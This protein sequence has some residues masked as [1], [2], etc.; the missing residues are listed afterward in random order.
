MFLHSTCAV[1]SQRFPMESPS[2]RGLRKAGSGGSAD[3]LKFGAEVRNCIWHLCRTGVKVMAMTTCLTARVLS[4]PHYNAL[5]ISKISRGG[6]KINVS[7][8]TIKISFWCWP[9]AENW[10]PHVCEP[11]QFQSTLCIFPY[12]L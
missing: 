6:V 9:P 1:L 8:N 11:S 7:R 5:T 12:F 2:Q 4:L 10:F 3:P